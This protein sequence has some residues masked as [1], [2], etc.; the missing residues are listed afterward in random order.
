MS[1]LS[2]LLLSS[3]LPE[4]AAQE[5][6]QV[7]ESPRIL[8]TGHYA[9][10]VQAPGEWLALRCTGASTCTLEP[11]NVIVASVGSGS[12]VSVEGEPALALLQNLQPGEIQAAHTNPQPLPRYTSIKLGSGLRL[13]ADGQDGY[14][15]MLSEHGLAQP[16]L[17]LSSTQGTPSL[18]FAG[19]LDGDGQLDLIVDATGQKEQYVSLLL[20][21]SFAPEGDKLVQVDRFSARIPLPSVDPAPPLLRQ[22]V[23]LGTLGTTEGE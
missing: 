18:R 7:A 3:L 21:S 17:E 11:A 22:E 4:V 14:R 23:N 19:D 13:V 5:T 12:I 9:E 10:S 1:P 6:A 8:L 15:L 20:L 2:V 16:V